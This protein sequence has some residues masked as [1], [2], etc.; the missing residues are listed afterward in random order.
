LRLSQVS[1]GA[2]FLADPDAEPA[3]PDAEGRRP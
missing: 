1:D 3:N 2:S